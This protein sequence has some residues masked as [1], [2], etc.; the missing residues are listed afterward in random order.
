MPPPDVTPERLRAIERL[1]H[2]ARERTP[3][4]RDTFLAGACAGDPELRREVESLLA[5]PPAGMIDAPMGAL[6][7]G[8]VAPASVLVAGKRIGVFEVQALLGV[9]GMG[10]VYR[11]RDTR[12]GR[13]VAI[14]ILPHAFKDDP[15]RLA[16]FER[17]ARV[18]AS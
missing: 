5:Q 14:K 12:L 8:L 2:E 10:E 9:G 11:A 3:A 16:R 6:L 7:A 4:E 15:E 1:F 18:L 13:E 17:E